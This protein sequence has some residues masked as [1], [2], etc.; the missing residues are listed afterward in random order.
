MSG[1]R[2]GRPTGARQ[3]FEVLAAQVR[4]GTCA[5]VGTRLA[6]P[7]AMRL[8]WLVSLSFL[9][10]CGGSDDGG[11]IDAHWDQ[12]D[13]PH[14]DA[15]PPDGGGTGTICGGKGGL[16]C[17]ATHYCEWTDNS[18]GGADGTGTCQPR[19]TGCPDPIYVPTCG[20]D[21]VIYGGACDAAAAGADV[22]VYNFCTPP[23]DTFACGQLFCATGQQY[24]QRQLSDVG[25]YADDYACLSLPGACGA[26][27][28]CA[29]LAA[30]PCGNA[31]EVTGDGL[32]LTCPGG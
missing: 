1:Q 27:P 6:A 28:D 10:A 22:N 21:N 9:V 26:T 31:C 20:C 18:C 19:P 24:C 15:T 12:D 14:L 25:G 13:A 23:A 7:G 5:G 30:E 4:A 2:G 8:A 32:R 17:D 16:T 29:C 11:A 3:F